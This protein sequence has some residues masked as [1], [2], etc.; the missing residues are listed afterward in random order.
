MRILVLLAIL[1]LCSCTVYDEAYVEEQTSVIEHSDIEMG[2]ARYI[3]SQSGRQ[4]VVM[5]SARMSYWM[6]DNRIE[7]E[8][9]VFSQNGEDG[10]PDISGSAGRAVIDTDAETMVLEGSVR[11][12]SKS[13][14]LS[15]ASDHLIFDTANS[16]VETDGAFS[17]TFDSGA[18]RGVGLYA[19]LRSMQVD[20]ASLDDGEVSY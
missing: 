6:D 5:E 7:A 4:P 12:E 18:M 16:T 15:I 9:P 2:R 3:L 1:S 14:S 20:I 13:A 17:I 8:S 19:D 11:L 10:E